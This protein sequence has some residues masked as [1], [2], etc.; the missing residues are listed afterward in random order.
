VLTSAGRDAALSAIFTAY[1]YVGLV[2]SVT[3]WRAGTVTE[4]SYTGYGVRPL[5]SWGGAA[6][7][8]PTAGR[9]RANAAAVVFPQN[10][11]SSQDQI[12][13]GL[14]S[15]ST[16]GTLGAL[17]FLDADA[18]ILGTGEITSENITAPA[19][20]LSTSQRVY[21]LACPG[22]VIPTGLSENVAYFVLAAGLTADVFRLSTTSGGA[23]VN[24]TV[25]GAALFIP[26]TVVA[27][28]AA[29]TPTFAIGTLVVQE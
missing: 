12:G 8:S 27:A 19:H 1:P 4:A 15:A 28:T 5:A 9:Q 13:F 23:A 25:S 6:N 16:A 7:T 11:G 17:G 14:W 18:P 24:I 3:D 2:R 20:G 26:Y 22:T 21:V 29:T 10:T